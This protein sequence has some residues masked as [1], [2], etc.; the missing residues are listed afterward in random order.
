MNKRQVAI[1]A[2]YAP[3]TASISAK[4]I[5]DKLSSNRIFIEEMERR[6]LTVE[7]IVGEIKR[8]MTEGM[9]PQHPDQPDN[10]N[11]RAYT[12]M[13]IRLYGSYAPTKLDVDID[14]RQM[15][16]ELSPDTIRA[17]EKASK[18]IEEDEPI[19]EEFTPD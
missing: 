4:K 8:G 12:D 13:A 9:H 3:S 16:I 14:H 15:T 6:G 17:I 1:H 5:T 10:Y 7:V 19:P 11:R 2:S 18:E